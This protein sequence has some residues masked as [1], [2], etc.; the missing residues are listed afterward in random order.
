MP[1]KSAKKA[2][3]PKEAKRKTKT[4]MSQV[5]KTHVNVRVGTGGGGG[6]SMSAPIV[7]AT[8]ARR[9]L[10]NQRSSFSTTTCPRRPSSKNQE[11]TSQRE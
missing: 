2:T 6:R 5:Q 9:H 7:Y 3:R 1:P 8:Y 11:S 4:K 10:R